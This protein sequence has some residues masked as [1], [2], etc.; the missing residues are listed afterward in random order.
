MSGGRGGYLADLGALVEV[1]GAEGAEE[2]E[3]DKD[4]HGVE[5]VA[6]QQVLGDV[7]D[8]EEQDQKELDDVPEAAEV[9]DEAGL[10]EDGPQQQLEG[11]GHHQG[12]L[13]DGQD[14]QRDEQG[15]LRGDLAVEHAH[16]QLQCDDADV[17]QQQDHHGPLQPRRPQQ[18]PQPLL[19][20]LAAR[21][22]LALLVAERSFAGVNS[23]SRIPARC[24][25]IC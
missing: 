19:P 9:A 5:E 21:L 24:K 16:K 18:P 2:A 7:E 14:D 15:L 11:E 17:Q 25:G 4:E 20:C 3:A 23:H 1:Q 6:V 10:G 12:E 22:A 8:A 13:G